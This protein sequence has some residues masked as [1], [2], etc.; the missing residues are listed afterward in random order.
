MKERATVIAISEQHYRKSGR[1]SE[2]CG[3]QL[4]SSI[5]GDE[6]AFMG[7]G[8]FEIVELILPGNRGD[9]ELF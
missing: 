8:L 5:S 3:E 1:K 6:N 7:V 9:A 4:E 2:L